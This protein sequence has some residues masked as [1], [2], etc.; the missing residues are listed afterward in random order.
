MPQGPSSFHTAP[1]CFILP[2]VYPFDHSFNF[3]MEAPENAEVSLLIY[4][5]KSGKIRT[6]LP[7]SGNCRRG[8]VRSV[9]AEGL[10]PDIHT[11][12]YLVDGKVVHDPLAHYITGRKEF[13]SAYPEDPHEIRCGLPRHG[14]FDW[15]EDCPPGIPY[16]EMILYKVHVRGYT[17]N[18]RGLVKKKGTFQGLTEM[19][20]YW[21]RLG[22]NAVELM[23]AYEFPEVTA[24]LPKSGM[25]SKKEEPGRMYRPP[26]LRLSIQSLPESMWSTSE[27]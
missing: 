9:L 5:G 8:R 15:G 3:T 1:G 18:A 2:G 6:E 24:P 7:I 20:P 16:E 14:M 12:N 10:S 22:I 17:K 25:V 23:P 21:K 11:Y 4:E 19:I 26:F 27:R 13:G